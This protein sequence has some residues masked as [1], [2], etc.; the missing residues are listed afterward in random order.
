MGK[1]LALFGSVG[2]CASAYS[3]H[4]LERP[5][6]VELLV[7]LIKKEQ[8]VAPNEVLPNP[9][10]SAETLKTCAPIGLHL[11]TTD[12]EVISSSSQFLDV[13]DCGNMGVQRVRFAAACVRQVSSLETMNSMDTTTSA[14]SLKSLDRIGQAK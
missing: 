7:F 2:Y 5:R 14:G 9:Y 11:Q 4:A 8:V 6:E 13:G 12:Y 10:V 3:F 1:G